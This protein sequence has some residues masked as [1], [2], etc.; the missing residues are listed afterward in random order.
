MVQK[1]TAIKVQKRNSQRVNIYLDGEFAFGL[2]RITA[3]WLYVGQELSEEKVATLKAE[4]TS[5]VAYQQALKFISYR[6]RSEAEVRRNLAG[7]K[8]PEDVIQETLEKLRRSGLVDDTRF[9]QLWVENRS[10]FRPRS[11]RALVVELRQH[12]LDD[13]TIEE[14][15]EEIDDEDLAYQAALKHTLKW[16]PLEWQTFR[17]KLSAFLARRGFGYDIT[18]ATVRRV[19][20]EIGSQTDDID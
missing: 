8:H 14:A 3:A 17:Q 4:D 11:R 19:W 12:G 13:S 7:H 10:E 20:D 18:A 2:A 6:Q 1:I 15:V 9:A 16:Q 5:E